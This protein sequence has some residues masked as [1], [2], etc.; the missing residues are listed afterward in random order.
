MWPLKYI[1]FYEK[2]NKS[3]KKNPNRPKTGDVYLCS[4]LFCTLVNKCILLF[5]VIETQSQ[6]EGG[7]GQQPEFVSVRRPI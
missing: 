4:L 5:N 3:H 6:Q 7:G 1:V 2:I